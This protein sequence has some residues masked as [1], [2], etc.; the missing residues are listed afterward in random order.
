[1]LGPDLWSFEGNDGPVTVFR[2]IFFET[3]PFVYF[4]STNTYMDITFPRTLC[5]DYVQFRQIRWTVK[6]KMTSW[7]SR[8][9]L[10]FS[11]R[12]REKHHRN[13]CMSP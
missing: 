8:G 6:Q 4:H 9:G 1:M 5:P 12:E 13:F 10:H 7:R 11:Y 2:Y 3:K